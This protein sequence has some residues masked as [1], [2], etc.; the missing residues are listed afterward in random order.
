MKDNEIAKRETKEVIAYS[1]SKDNQT[2]TV[3]IYTDTTYRIK[4]EGNWDYGDAKVVEGDKYYGYRRAGYT[5]A[6]VMIVNGEYCLWFP[7]SK[8]VKKVNINSMITSEIKSV[9]I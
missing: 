3:K 1:G 8:Y 9:K 7:W 5:G 2:T 4:A 6:Y